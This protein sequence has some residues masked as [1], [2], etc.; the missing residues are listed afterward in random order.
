MN[1]FFA[2]QDK[3]SLLL[4]SSQFGLIF[5]YDRF[6]LPILYLEQDSQ[7]FSF[8]NPFEGLHNPQTY[9][10]TLCYQNKSIEE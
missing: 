2:R 3:V 10:E 5:H 4:Y 9:L 7:T 1:S 8:R 6:L